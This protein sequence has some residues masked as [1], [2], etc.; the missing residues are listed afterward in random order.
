MNVGRQD[1]IVDVQL[2]LQLYLRGGHV[3]AFSGPGEDLLDFSP[4]ERFDATV[5][6][7][8]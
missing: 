4:L 8:Y 2:Q 5:T 7:S 6:F 3:Q 1:A